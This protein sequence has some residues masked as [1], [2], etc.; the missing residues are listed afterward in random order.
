M[1][2]GPARTASS[3]DASANYYDATRNCRP[4]ASTACVAATTQIGDQG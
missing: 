1:Y 2:Y 3:S 4:S